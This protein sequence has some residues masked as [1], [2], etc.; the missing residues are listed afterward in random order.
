MYVLKLHLLVSPPLHTH[1]SNNIPA[2]GWMFLQ[3]F[4][5]LFFLY[6]VII[7]SK[8]FQGHRNL[9]EHR[10]IDKCHLS[11][12]SNFLWTNIL[13]EEKEGKIFT[14]FPNCKFFM[15]KILN[16]S[17]HRILPYFTIKY[18]TDFTCNKQR[19]RWCMF[20]WFPLTTLFRHFQVVLDPRSNNLFQ[21][22]ADLLK[23]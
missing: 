12:H 17:F 23:E 9:Q 3:L 7:T 18:I 5:F 22:H 2:V 4:F 6:T 15:K 1:K 13:Q 8:A 19:S 21:E 10:W 11:H 16:N 14:I 20:H